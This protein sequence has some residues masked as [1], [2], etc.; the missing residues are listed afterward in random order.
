M[1][2]FNRVWCAAV[3]LGGFAAVGTAW[4]FRGTAELA[5][6]A[7][8]AAAKFVSTLTA[9]QKDAVVFD[10][11][12]PERVGWHFIPK[13]ERKGLP[14][15]EM[16]DA[17]RSSLAGI[18]QSILSETGY[19]KVNGARR[20]EGLVRDLEGEGRR[21]ARNPDDYFLS[22]F[23]NP[24]ADGRWGVSFEGH[25]VS[26]NFTFDKGRIIS[27]TP[28]F[29][30]AHPAVILQGQERDGLETGYQLLGAEAT[31]AFELGKSLSD[32]QRSVAHLSETAAKE[33]QG[34]G[35]AQPPYSGN[36]GLAGREMTDAQRETLS[37][38]ITLYAEVAA[39]P[40]AQRRLIDINGLDDVTFSYTGTLKTGEPHGYTILGKTFSIEY[41]NSQADAE[42]NPANHAHSIWRDMR[43][44]FAISR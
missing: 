37:E 8:Q 36:A 1:V 25:H 20:L 32:S 26:M 18:L 4:S 28:Q 35:E 24:S 11:A 34:A 43:G 9:E 6:G 23:G 7:H 13:D 42:G 29:L 3:V 19:D 30:G 10:F 44:D 38:L 41:V 22:F 33:I 40:V 12:A 16:T 5:A 21:W 31:L 14:V 15:K 39:A 17:Q 27:S 2:R